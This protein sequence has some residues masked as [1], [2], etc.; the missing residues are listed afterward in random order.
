MYR[1]SILYAQKKYTHLHSHHSTYIFLSHMVLKIFVFCLIRSSCNN[2]RG[3]INFGLKN[4]NHKDSVRRQQNL[5][6]CKTQ[7]LVNGSANIVQINILSH[8]KWLMVTV[9]LHKLWFIITN[10]NS[11]I[12]VQNI[13]NDILSQNIFT[14]QKSVG[15][16]KYQ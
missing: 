9:M 1:K 6:T 14:C 13:T 2:N 11:K 4:N 5:Q 16:L 15:S 8:V 12:G 7:K 10:F 3:F